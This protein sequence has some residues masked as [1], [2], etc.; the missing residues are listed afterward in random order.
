[1]FYISFTFEFQLLVRYYKEILLFM[2]LDVFCTRVSLWL[3]I[4]WHA[5]FVFFVYMVLTI[6]VPDVQC[7]LYQQVLN[8]IV[9]IVTLWP[10]KLSGR[11]GEQKINIGFIERHL[12]R[13]LLRKCKIFTIQFAVSTKMWV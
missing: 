1:M 9:T 4:F 11:G 12:K 5:V 7:T 13:P 8:E 3:L 6:S 10:Y 2:S